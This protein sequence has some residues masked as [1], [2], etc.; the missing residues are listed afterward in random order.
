MSEFS[1][2]GRTAVQ[3]HKLKTLLHSLSAIS[4]LFKTSFTEIL[5][6]FT[7]AVEINISNMIHGHYNWIQSCYNTLLK[8]FQI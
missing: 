8:L 1:V 5:N 3:I 4:F 2:D 7:N 6:E